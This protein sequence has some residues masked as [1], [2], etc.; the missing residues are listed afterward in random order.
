MTTLGFNL[1]KTLA[2]STRAS[3]RVEKPPVRHVQV[4][5]RGDAQ[6]LAGTLRLRQPYLRSRR[7]RSR[8]AVRQIDDSYSVTLASQ[9]GVSICNPHDSDTIKDLQESLMKFGLAVACIYLFSALSTA[10]TA[11]TEE[12]PR[13]SLDVPSGAPL[14][15]YLTKRILQTGR[16]SRGGKTSGTG[17]CVRP[18]GGSRRDGGCRA[19]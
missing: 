12:T 3:K 17:L 7:V 8:L 14:R 11:T 5:P 16:R 10:Q 13:I 9:P 6:D 15:L 2:S 1:R 18:R 19:K 4:D